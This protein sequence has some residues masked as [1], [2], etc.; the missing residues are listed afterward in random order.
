MSAVGAAWAGRRLHFVGVGGAGMSAY[1]RA[2]RAL[3]A[4]VSGSDAAESAYTRELAADGVLDARIGHAAANVPPGDDVELVYS[5]AVPFDNVERAA[6]RA[7]G[8]S[9]A[10]VVGKHGL[11]NAALPVVTIVGLQFGYLLGGA[12]ITETIF[13]W[14]GIGLFTVTAINERDF[15]VV[16]AAVVVASGMF[17]GLNVLVDLLYA[18]LDPR[19]RLS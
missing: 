5:S 12:V 16:Q 19:I 8:L 3:G 17:I 11:K 18:W 6:A 4:Q 1:A 10:L 2:A 14:P 9:E 13:G 7:R 15:P